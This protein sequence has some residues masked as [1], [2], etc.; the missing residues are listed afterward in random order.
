LVLPLIKSICA[1]MQ[2]LRV[3]DPGVSEKD[4]SEIQTTMLGPEVQDVARYPK[5]VFRSTSIE[6]TTTKNGIRSNMT[7][8]G[9]SG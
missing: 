1:W 5:I 3:E 6:K 8:S 9:Q 7:I 2:K 4:R